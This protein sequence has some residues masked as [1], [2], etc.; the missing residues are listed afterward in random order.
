M[1]KKILK[2][3]IKSVV[4][5]FSHLEKLV[6]ELNDYKELMK[7]FAWD[8]EPFLDM[9][10]IYE[11][12]SDVDLN[13]RRIRDAESIGLVMKNQTPA[14]ALEIG[15]AKGLTTSLMSLNSTDS[16]IYTVNIPADEIKSG[17]GG[18]YTTESFSSDEIG[19]E[20][21]KRKLKNVNQIYANTA[22]WKPDIGEIDFLFV[23]GCHDTDFVY[24][25]TKKCL[26]FMKEGS[27]ILWHDFNLN[28]VNKYNWIDSVCKGVE[29]LC[30]EN[31]INKRIY[32][33]KDSWIGIYR[34]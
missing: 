16:K 13:Q 2:S 4:S 26:E 7:V 34:I 17:E 31:L 29:K 5:D 10:E 1:I 20:Y 3:K 30:A 28:L 33:I 21:K 32:T 11:Y 8:K 15:T 6:I 12:Q 24:N 27:F 9:D 22:T 19:I 14:V 25:D 23:D 18:K